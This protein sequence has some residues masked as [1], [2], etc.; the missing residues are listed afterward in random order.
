RRHT[1]L[2]SDWSSDVCS[3]D[4]D[5]RLPVIHVNW[6]EAD[7]YCRWA[8]RRLPTEAEWE[9]AASAERPA[10]GRGLTTRKRRYPWGDDLPTPERANLDWLAL[11]C[12]SVAALPAGDCA[13][14]CHQ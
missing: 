1:R 13:F 14:G 4:L 5:D 9:M 3:S 11:G 8:E 10:N 6:H 12:M 2:V 7:A